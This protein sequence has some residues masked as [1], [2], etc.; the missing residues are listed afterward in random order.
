VKINRRGTY[1]VKSEI[2]ISKLV[3]RTPHPTGGSPVSKQIRITEIQITKTADNCLRLFKFCTF[4]NSGFVFVSCFGFRISNLSAKHF[5][6]SLWLVNKSAYGNLVS[7]VC[8]A[9]GITVNSNALC[10]CL[11]CTFVSN[12]GI[13]K[14]LLALWRRLP[15]SCHGPRGKSAC[16][17]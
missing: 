15:V 12:K 16:S 3:L 4:E 6:V 9:K 11:C 7:T 1:P 13:S 14:K 17:G 10:F 8:G 5:F 2:R